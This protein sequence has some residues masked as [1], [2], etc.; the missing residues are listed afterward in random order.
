[1]TR[2]ETNSMTETL[3]WSAQNLPKPKTTPMLRFAVLAVAAGLVVIVAA[4]TVKGPIQTT[5]TKMEPARFSA[6]VQQTGATGIVVAAT[7]N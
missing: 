5:G 3:A 6:P 1:M 7:T 4:S 2:S